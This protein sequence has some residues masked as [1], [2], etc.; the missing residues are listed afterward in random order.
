MCSLNKKVMY[1]C[2]FEKDNVCFN[3]IC[4]VGSKWNWCL[5]YLEFWAL[6]VALK[7]TFLFF[8]FGFHQGQSGACGF[9]IIAGGSLNTYCDSQ[10][11]VGE[12]CSDLAAW[13]SNKSLSYP[14]SVVPFWW[15]VLLRFFFF[16]NV[17]DK[18]NKCIKK[19]RDSTNNSNYYKIQNITP[20][21]LE[22]V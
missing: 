12:T 17:N 13:K 18:W 21:K 19:W 3:K 7:L 8:W 15:I 2:T 1:W 6:T 22:Q 14:F 4:C 9:C 16:F 5:E 11:G 10:L 20:E